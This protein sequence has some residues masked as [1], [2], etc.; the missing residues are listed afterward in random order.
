MSGAPAR[1]AGALLALACTGCA[2]LE[3]YGVDRLRDLSDVVDVRY[4]T[5][6]GLGLQ[7]DA[8]M[9]LGTGL[10][11]SDIQRS[12]A[13]FGRHSVERGETSFFGLILTSVM[14]GGMCGA[15]PAMGWWNMF[16]FNLAMLDV[17]A[18][19]PDRAWFSGTFDNAPP[20]FDA[21][22]FGGTVFLPGVHG[23]LY[24]NAGEAVDF[25]GGL[26]TLDLAHDDGI[27]KYAPAPAPEAG[28]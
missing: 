22:R 11:W 6:L 17:H 4:G 10:G 3:Q 8:T 25:I 2:T 9:W 21:F 7:V 12:R 1:L 15:S 19:G 20:A 24:L 14:G 23:G 5:G 13:W 28:A 26:F 18:W 27:P 16:G